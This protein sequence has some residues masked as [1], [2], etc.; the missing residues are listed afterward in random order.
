MFKLDA[1]R[2]NF[3]FDSTFGIE[4]S[5]LAMVLSIITCVG[6]YWFGRKN[7]ALET[8]IWNKQ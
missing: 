6:L 4:G 5:I 3:A 7:G 8:N 1:S 2:N